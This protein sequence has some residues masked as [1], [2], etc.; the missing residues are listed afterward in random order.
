MTADACSKDESELRGKA[1]KRSWLCPGA[2]FALIGRG[3]Y[4][5]ATFIASLGF[6]PALA[7]IAFQPTAVSLWTSI[8]VLVVATALW[9]GEQVAIKKASLRAPNPSF[10]DRR[11]IASTCAMWLAALLGVGILASAF[12][13]LRMGGA[14]MQPTLEKGERLIYHKRVDWQSVRPGAVIVY[15]NAEDSAW[16]RPGWILISRVLAGPGD[17]I[18]IDDGKY[19]VNGAAGPLVAGTGNFDAVL[20][21]PSSPESL[22]IPDGC[23]FIVQD[24]PSGGFDSRV[25][26]WVRAADIIGSRLWRVSDR[27]FCQPVP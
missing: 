26:S 11:F 14:G 7:W 12:G 20:D 3:T 25:L 27:G 9:V 22:T 13:S 24:S 2:G 18:S 6:L 4:A 19:I 17:S 23:Y 8:A 5:I 10:L 15:R 21:V 16:G 1:V